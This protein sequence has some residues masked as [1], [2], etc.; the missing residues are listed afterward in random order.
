MESMDI[1]KIPVYT[2][3][4]THII[5]T[6]CTLYWQKTTS[7]L[8][9]CPLVYSLLYLHFFAPLLVLLK[10]WGIQVTSYLLLKDSSP[11]QLSDKT[12]Q[13]LQA[14]ELIINFNKS[15]FQPSLCLE[16]LSLVQ[17]TPQT[18]IFLAEK[19]V[20]FLSRIKIQGTSQIHIL[21]KS[22]RPKGSPL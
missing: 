5:S 3:P 13:M 19:R 12:L 20:L 17:D 16:N 9:H 1:Q 6:F 4:F 14:F 11:L 8:W 10:T 21:H 18:K 2:F 22:T 15:A 7:S